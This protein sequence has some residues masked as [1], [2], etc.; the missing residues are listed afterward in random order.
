MSAENIDSSSRKDQKTYEQDVKNQVK[1]AVSEFTAALNKMGLE[2]Q[3]AEAAFVQ[4]ASEHRTLQQ[5]FWRCVI[6][7]AEKYGNEASSDQRNEASKNACKLMT[8]ALK[9]T[10][11]PFV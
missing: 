8:E 4:L 3:V 9:D 5:N 6:S 10:H 11:L 2:D 7:M 1:K